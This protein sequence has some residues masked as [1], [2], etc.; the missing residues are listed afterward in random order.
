MSANGTREPSTI[1]L[2]AGIGEL[3]GL[4]AALLAETRAEPIQ[5]GVSDAHGQGL[6]LEH[7]PVTG[8]KRVLAYRTGNGLGSGLAVPTTGVLVFP[9][10]EARIGCTL[11]NM[12][13]NAALVYL[14]D[15]ARQ[16]APTIWLAA[17]GGSWDGMFG[18]VTWAGNIFAV[19][20]T[21]ATTFAGGE[22]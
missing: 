4:L 10:N 21:T 18:N 19:A 3:E 13:A 2:A 17:N 1:A 22:L 5:L 16:G 6:T 11:V 12:G 9:A 8:T 7:W 14:S 15:Q 20:I